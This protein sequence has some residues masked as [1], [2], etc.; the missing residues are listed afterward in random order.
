[1]GGSRH[2]MYLRGAFTYV[3]RAEFRERRFSNVGGFNN[4]LVTGNRLPYSP[5]GLLNTTLGYQ[6]A[7]G[8]NA[9]IEGVYTGRQFGDD[10]NTIN[11]TADGQRGAIPSNM[12][13]NTTLN[14]PLERWRTTVFISS[15]NLFDR[16]YIADRTRGIIPGIRRLV[17]VGFR[18]NF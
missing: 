3:A 17:Q 4:I 14:Y 12:I 8:M 7:S 13:W 5:G 15:K 6:H 16:T 2:S 11:S 1:M 9:M 18:W 10:L